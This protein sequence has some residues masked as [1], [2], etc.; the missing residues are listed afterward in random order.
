MNWLDH[1]CDFYSE[2]TG[3][4]SESGRAAVRKESEFRYTGRRDYLV[5]WESLDRKTK[6]YFKY[7]YL[8]VNGLYAAPSGTTMPGESI[9]TQI[10][11]KLPHWHERSFELTAKKPLFGKDWKWVM[12]GDLSGDVMER[13]KQ[14][15][16]SVEPERP[17]LYTI[18]LYGGS[19]GFDRLVVE[20]PVLRG[21]GGNF[22]Y[23]TGYEL[24]DCGGKLLSCDDA[25]PVIFRKLLALSEQTADLLES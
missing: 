20:T 21:D 22:R 16:L 8:R 10:L 12:N 3:D 25:T 24:R 14:M 5:T 6:E 23:D 13:I 19:D 18:R 7:S 2:L 4:T 15:L 11:C 1:L 17:D 9:Y